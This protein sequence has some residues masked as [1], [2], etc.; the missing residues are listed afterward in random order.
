M[1]IE[2]IRFSPTDVTNANLLAMRPSNIDTTSSF[3]D[4]GGKILAA[5]E[6]SWRADAELKGEIAGAAVA[7]VKNEDGSYAVPVIPEA[8]T[9]Y[10][11]AFTNAMETN[12]ANQ[13]Y[14]D[15]SKTIEQ[16][17]NENPRDAEAFRAK[18]EGA[19]TGLLKT[20]PPQLAAKI[21]PVLNR[22]IL[23]RY[24]AI[25]QRKSSEDRQALLQGLN[26]AEIAH[27]RDGTER[28]SA[29]L[30]NEGDAAFE[31]ARETHNQY[32]AL[33][34]A[35]DE[36][37]VNALNTTIE[38]QKRVG[39]GMSIE[40]AMREREHALSIAERDANRADRA[41]IAADKDTSAA[42]LKL[43]LP[44]IIDLDDKNLATLEGMINGSFHENDT[45][46]I[47][48]LTF[49]YEDLNRL[50]PDAGYQ[51]GSLLRA[52]NATQA[53]RAADA[54]AAERQRK[55]DDI[56]RAVTNTMTTGQPPRDPKVKDKLNQYGAQQFDLT[57]RAGRE[58]SYDFSKTSGYL[59]ETQLDWLDTSARNTSLDANGTGGTYFTA[60]GY[61]ENL[62]DASRPNAS[63]PGELV[64]QGA[65]LLSQIDPKTNDLFILGSTLRK[66]P[67]YTPSMVAASVKLLADGVA[68][69]TE[70][71]QRAMLDNYPSKR[72][73]SLAN[74]LGI[75]NT[76]SLPSYIITDYDRRF[77]ALS[78][79]LG[80]EKAISVT[81]QYFKQEYRK[82]PRFVSGIGNTSYD[83]D[84][85]HAA[86]S[87]YVNENYGA[88]GINMNDL[89][90]SVKVM[91]APSSTPLDPTYV[92]QYVDKTGATTHSLMLRKSQIPEFKMRE[93]T[94]VEIRDAELKAAQTDRLQSMSM[95]STGFDPMLGENMAPATTLSAA[96]MKYAARVQAIEDKFV[97]ARAEESRRAALLANPG[98]K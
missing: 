23:E 72:N 3:P 19:A 64:N 70:T 84:M 51:T 83:S 91:K 96:D 79:V 40:R 61:W 62:L 53:R 47:G 92:Y 85:P 52:V 77:Y 76:S 46:T 39:R 50:I 37:D 4:L 67:G 15:Y 55:E 22:E 31:R 90:G 6:P 12:Y 20:I 13:V 9:V 74:E 29:G 58:A 27:I 36:S 63:N 28:Y 16:F 56:N 59:T 94:A 80:T 68:S 98:G 44:N 25:S 89:G 82:D 34:Q 97:R 73:V 2:K 87:K 30:F 14:F 5:M 1:A 43:I 7:V 18:A 26:E 49:N 10:Q 95:S 24:S 45:V 69:P 78:Q 17:R 88:L 81:T 65:L 75:A 57:D 71:Q 21:Q 60:L 35:T 8:G 54:A 93:F 48:E 41:R 38:M 66:I 86:V 33:I 32:R 42:T 11:E